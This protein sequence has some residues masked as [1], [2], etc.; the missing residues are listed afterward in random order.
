MRSDFDRFKRD[1]AFDMVSVV[2]LHG[3]DA[4]DAPD[5][6]GR[7]D[8]VRPLQNLQPSVLQLQPSGV[9]R[10]SFVRDQDDAPQ[11][12]HLDE[13]FQF[14]H[15]ALG[16]HVRLRMVGKARRPAGKGDAVISRQLQSVLKKIVELFA[17]AAVGTIDGGGVNSCPIVWNCALEGQVRFFM[18]NQSIRHPRLRLTL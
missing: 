12:M 11:T 5:R 13:E 18:H 8:Q 4:G 17:D 1:A 2:A 16:L 9:K 14:V 10:A 15:H 7:P 6:R 3:F